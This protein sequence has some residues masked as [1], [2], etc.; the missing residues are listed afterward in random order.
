[1]HTYQQQFFRYVPQVKLVESSSCKH[2]RGVISM[3]GSVESLSGSRKFAECA[4]R[5]GS[6]HCMA[7]YMSVNHRRSNA[8]S[9]FTAFT[10]SHQ[11]PTA[12]TPFRSSTPLLLTL[13]YSASQTHAES[14]ACF[15]ESRALAC[16]MLLLLGWTATAQQARVN[17]T[18]LLLLDV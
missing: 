15:R 10:S 9:V 13:P 4:G 17:R 2:Q 6:V 8:L 3:D 16:G 11:L 12:G 5:H 1:M 14:T 18:V 7:L